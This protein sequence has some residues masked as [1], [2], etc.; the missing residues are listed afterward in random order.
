MGYNSSVI[1][2]TTDDDVSEDEENLDP[3]GAIRSP[4]KSDPAR[5]E[6]LIVT[7][8]RRKS[9]ET[10]NWSV[11]VN[12]F[13]PSDCVVSPPPYLSPSSPRFQGFLNQI[14]EGQDTFSE[15]F[16]DEAGI[17]TNPSV[18][19]LPIEYFPS[20][21]DANVYKASLNELRKAFANVDHTFKAF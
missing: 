14:G 9:Q 21:M 10:D 16:E 13:F 1:R 4:D 12:K 7:L 2:S 6:S 20:N 11:R 18:E 3:L 15:V 8:E 5:R 19:V 17:D